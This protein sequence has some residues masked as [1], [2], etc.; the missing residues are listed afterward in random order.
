MSMLSRPFV[1]GERSQSPAWK[2]GF[3]TPALCL[4]DLFD[5]Q[6]GAGRRI[7]KT[8]NRFQPF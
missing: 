5:L 1:P 4:L 3:P 7:Q 6:S 8:K 2:T